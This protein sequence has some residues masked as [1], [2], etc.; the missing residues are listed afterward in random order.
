MRLV[1]KTED[2]LTKPELEYTSTAAI[3]LA[4][5][6]NN[7]LS[8][9]LC[10]FYLVEESDWSLGKEQ[11]S[12]FII[13][14]SDLRSPNEIFKI[15][16]SPKRKSFL[17]DKE[18]SE[19]TIQVV[20]RKVTN[21][22]VIDISPLTGVSLTECAKFAPYFPYDNSNGGEVGKR[23]IYA[24]YVD[25]YFKAHEFEAKN[26]SPSTAI[27]KEIVCEFVPKEYVIGAFECEVIERKQTTTTKYILNSQ[28]L[29]WNDQAVPSVPNYEERKL[30]FQNEFKKLAKYKFL[31]LTVDN[32]KKTPSLSV[33][34]AIPEEKISD[35]SSI[36]QSNSSIFKS[37][38]QSSTEIVTRNSNNEANQ[39][40][41]PDAINQ[42]LQAL[43]FS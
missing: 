3:F 41:T 30:A 5:Y 40:L 37:F 26:N 20:M 18:T 42:S 23:Y 29:I 43:R 4:K 11:G 28:S 19:D 38:S 2:D 17:D 39:N 7:I 22:G 36:N 27:F 24:I 34:G 32:K 35:S 16:F 9:N 13:F 1:R 14:R 33:T 25:R 21:T 12:S 10:E 15:G 8:E 6:F 31:L